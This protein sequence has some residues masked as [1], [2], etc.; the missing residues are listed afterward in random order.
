MTEQL[1][2]WCPQEKFENDISDIRRRHEF[3]SLAAGDD[4]EAWLICRFCAQEGSAFKWRLA[5]GTTAIT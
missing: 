5:L 2:P 4:A 1:T 3:I